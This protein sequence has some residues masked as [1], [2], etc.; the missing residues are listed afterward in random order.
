MAIKTAVLRTESEKHRASGGRGLVSNRVAGPRVLPRL[1]DYATG[2]A[3]FAKGWFDLGTG[4]MN[5]GR[6]VKGMESKN[7]EI[8]SDNKVLDEKKKLDPSRADLYEA[9]KTQPVQ[10]TSYW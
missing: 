1:G 7:E 6:N 9:Q 3:A 2:I 8:M 10:F 5:H 4:I